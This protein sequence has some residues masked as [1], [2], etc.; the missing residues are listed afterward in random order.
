MTGL[1]VAAPPGESGFET[2]GLTTGIVCVG[3][4]GFVVGTV[5]KG[6]VMSAWVVEMET[7]KGSSCSWVSSLLCATTNQL[8][9]KLEPEQRK[10]PNWMNTKRQ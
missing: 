7:K 9:F 10:A 6:V 3:V 4:L 8:S 1:V 5:G 2:A